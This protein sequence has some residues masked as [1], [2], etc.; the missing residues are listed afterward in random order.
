ME[1]QNERNADTRVVVA[2]YSYANVKQSARSIEPIVVVT[3]CSH[4]RR[5]GH[6]DNPES[7]PIASA[8]VAGSAITPAPKPSAE[9]P[10]RA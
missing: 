6:A 3:S 5:R 7:T 10:A 9:S 4:K 8:A 1:S 2:G